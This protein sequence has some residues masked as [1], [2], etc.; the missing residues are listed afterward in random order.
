MAD[1]LGNL[2]L[3]VGWLHLQGSNVRSFEVNILI[4]YTSILLS[5]IT[6]FTK[7]IEL[8]NDFKSLTVANKLN[9]WWKIFILCELGRKMIEFVNYQFF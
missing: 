8:I 9:L 2:Q 1:V 4:I 5:H 6:Y 7:Y 3:A